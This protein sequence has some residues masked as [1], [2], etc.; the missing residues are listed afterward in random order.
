MRQSILKDITYCTNDQ[1]DQRKE[2]RRSLDNV[3]ITKGTLSIA[4]FFPDDNNYCQYKI[5]F[6]KVNNKQNERKY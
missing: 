3:K 6:D 5:D 4:M 2:C 1:C